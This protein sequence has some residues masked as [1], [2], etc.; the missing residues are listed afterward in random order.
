MSSPVASIYGRVT[1]NGVQTRKSRKTGK[2][3]KIF[4][5][6]AHVEQREPRDAGG[7]EL[8]DPDERQRRPWW[9]TCYAT[10]QETMES[11][12]T[13]AARD[14]TQV[15]GRLQRR[16]WKDSRNNWREEWMMFVDS[17]AVLMYGSRFPA[18]PA[19]DEPGAGD[20]APV[21]P[22][23]EPEAVDAPADPPADAET[24]GETPSAAA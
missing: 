1:R 7:R 11:A 20:G 13:L 2:N 14:Y 12:S 23:A 15:T 22:D 18:Q 16:R 10:S 3:M 6:S 17:M 8:T 24:A 21:D 19:D 5:M 9:V 4:T